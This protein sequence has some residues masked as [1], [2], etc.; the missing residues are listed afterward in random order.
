MKNLV[1]YGFFLFLWSASNRL[2]EISLTL[3]LCV[4]LY[5][6]NISWDTDR[7]TELET[8]AVHISND[9]IRA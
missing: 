2:G 3:A 4:D 6:C 5:K 9:S 8:R 1:F 7:E